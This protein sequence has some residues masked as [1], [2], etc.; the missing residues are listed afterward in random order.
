M[1]ASSKALLLS[2]KLMVTSACRWG[3]SS[4]PPVHNQM[5]G[6]MTMLAATAKRAAAASLAPNALPILQLGHEN[7]EQQ[8]MHAQDEKQ[9]HSAARG[10][11]QSAGKY[12]IQCSV[13]I[14]VH[15]NSSQGSNKHSA[16]PARVA[17]NIE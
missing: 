4:M 9:A 10:N 6:A 7:L 17:L 11:M 3:S 8:R 14:C 12:V 1:C 13:P 5:Q 2:V 15:D 16:R